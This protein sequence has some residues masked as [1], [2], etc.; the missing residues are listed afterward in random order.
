MTIPGFING[1]CVA[2]NLKM[3]GNTLSSTDTNGDINLTPNG[4]GTVNGTEL[5]LTTELDE[6]YG[7]TGNASYSAGDILYASNST[8]LTKLAPGTNGQVLTIS[9]GVPAWATG[10]TWVDVTGTSDAIEANTGYISN[11]AGL[12]TLTLPAS[13]AVGD[14]HKVAGLGAGGWLVAQNASQLI[15]FGNMDTTTG[16][17]GSLASSNRY[18]CIEL[19]CVVANT[20][21][22]ILNSVGVITVT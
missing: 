3:S 11:N 9:S 15:H 19:L 10:F 20:E 8:T 5:T 22:L 1:D 14:C 13:C 12:V 7:G 6:T 2:G 18:D 4:T 21:W 17:G 16:V